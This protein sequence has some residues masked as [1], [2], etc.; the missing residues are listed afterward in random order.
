[1]GTPHSFVVPCG[2]FTEF[3]QL[4]SHDVSHK[5]PIVIW[6]ERITSIKKDNYLTYIG[7][8]GGAVRMKTSSPNF[9]RDVDTR[10]Y[11]Y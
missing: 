6:F 1:M 9:T 10:M 11:Q 5:F 4:I 2:L 7:D 3:L 8:E